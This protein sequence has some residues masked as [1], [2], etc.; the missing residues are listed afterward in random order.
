ME[1][2][3]RVALTTNSLPESGITVRGP[4]C[5]GTHGLS[6]GSG[7]THGLSSISFLGSTL[8]GYDAWGHLS[9]LDNG[10]RV[11]SAPP[12]FPGTR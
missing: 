2:D 12:P 7:T 9:A 5:Y 11:K 1:G 4:H 3:D 8:N 10:I 6:I